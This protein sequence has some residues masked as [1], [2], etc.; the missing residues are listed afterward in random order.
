MKK[1][2]EICLCN[3]VTSLPQWGQYFA[4][5]AT[6]APQLEQYFTFCEVAGAEGAVGGGA[7]AYAG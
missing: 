6:W 1:K 4:S 3:Y 7:G 5:K 2:R